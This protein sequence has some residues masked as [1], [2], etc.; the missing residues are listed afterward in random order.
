MLT[1][2]KNVLA[3]VTKIEWIVLGIAA[4]ALFVALTKENSNKKHHKAEKAAE[5]V[6]ETK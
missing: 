1:K 2:I 4:L 3:K 5:A 6:V